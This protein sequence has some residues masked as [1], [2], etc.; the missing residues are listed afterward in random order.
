DFIRHAFLWEDG[1]LT[2]LGTLGGGFSSY[3]HGINNQSQVVGRSDIGGGFYNA[4]LWQD[5]V[6]MDLGTPYNVFSD[7]MDINDAGQITGTIDLEA[8]RWEDGVWTELG[9]LPGFA[10]S[11]GHGIN[12]SGEVVGGA[13]LC[14]FCPGRGFHWVVGVMSELGPLPGFD[15]SGALAINDV[16]LIVGAS[17]NLIP[18]APRATLWDKGEAIDLGM[19]EGTRSFAYGINSAGVIVGYWGTS[20]QGLDH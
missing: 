9:T 10:G 2:D 1:E 3:G 5:G 4:F 15:S 18:S 17:N 6:M 11:F 20:D 13:F 12:Q 7:A 8:Y 14:H 19:G 16:G